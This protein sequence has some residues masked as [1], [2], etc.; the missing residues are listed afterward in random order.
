MRII[1]R[2]CDKEKSE[3]N[4][5]KQSFKIN[6]LS[7]WCRNCHIEALQIAKKK[8]PRR[9]QAY[10]S[11]YHFRNREQRLLYFKERQ[12]IWKQIVLDFY[13][14]NTLSCKNCNINDTDVLT[15]DHINNDGYKHRKEIKGNLYFWLIKNN[16]PE[17]FQ[18][19]CFNCNHKKSMNDGV[20]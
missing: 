13:S 19:L 6:G 3:D 8:N 12:Q 10:N 11:E 14:N 15:I 4:F 17:G 18:V 9:V 1:C 16:F 20:L 5:Y 2:R 7:S